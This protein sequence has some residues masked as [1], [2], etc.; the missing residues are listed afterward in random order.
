MKK[1]YIIEPDFE[2]VSV[3]MR[4]MWIFWVTVKRYQSGDIDY[5]YCW[6]EDLLDL[7]NENEK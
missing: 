2:G 6:A 5:D 7:L 4:F 1:K 3:K